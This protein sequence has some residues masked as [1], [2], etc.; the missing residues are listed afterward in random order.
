MG[1]KKNNII[2]YEIRKG[3]TVKTQTHYRITPWKHN[4]LT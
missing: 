2:L 1:E 3:K 4:F